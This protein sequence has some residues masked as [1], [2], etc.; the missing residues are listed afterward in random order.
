M[1][2]TNLSPEILFTTCREVKPPTLATE[3]SAGYDFYIPEDFGNWMIAPGYSALIPSGIRMIIPKGFVG[4]FHN[5]SGLGSRGLDLG[6][7][8]VDSDY[9]GEI[10]INV[11]NVGNESLELLTGKAIAQMVIVPILNVNMTKISN[12]AFD[13][14]VTKRGAGGFGSTGV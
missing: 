10:V 8:V 14:D 9:R 3:G 5:K 2:E 1:K 11:R 6:A 4:I 13:L 12:E 7:C